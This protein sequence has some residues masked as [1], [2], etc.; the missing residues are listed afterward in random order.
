MKRVFIASVFMV[1]ICSSLAG[2]REGLDAAQQGDFKRALWTIP[3]PIDKPDLSEA[4]GSRVNLI[5]YSVEYFRRHQY[6]LFL[7][8]LLGSKYCILGKIEPVESWC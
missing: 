6:F 3:G 1:V 4:E 2:T 5:P 7:L 8:Y